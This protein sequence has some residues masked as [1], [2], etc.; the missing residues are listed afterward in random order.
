MF[1]GL[2][3]GEKNQEYKMSNTL[4]WHNNIPFKTSFLLRRSLR[5]KVPTN[6]KISSFGHDPT[7]C[8]YYYKY[9][10]DTID[11]IF[12]AGHFFQS[13]VE[14]LLWFLGYSTYYY[15][16]EKSDYEMLDL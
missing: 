7:D 4:M 2:G 12:F 9:G 5:G 8:F 16:I 15:F 6:E 11:H 13:C 1:F 3:Y 10:R 14:I